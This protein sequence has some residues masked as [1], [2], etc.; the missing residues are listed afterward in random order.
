MRELVCEIITCGEMT[1]EDEFFI[2]S[3]V[4]DLRARTLKYSLNLER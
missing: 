3:I 1:I 2:F 4:G